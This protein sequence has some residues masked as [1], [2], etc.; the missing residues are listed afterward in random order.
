MVAATPPPPVT[1]AEDHLTLALPVDVA[2]A[3]FLAAVISAE[4]KA[5]EVVVRFFA[6][7]I[8]TGD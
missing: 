3:A 8:T 7:G 1:M 4:L 2:G 6:V 5:E